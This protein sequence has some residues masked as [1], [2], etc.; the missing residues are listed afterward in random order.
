[1]CFGSSPQ[2]PEIK[3]QGP[4]DDDIA[5][6]EASLATYQQQLQ[7]QQAASA[8]QLQEQIDAANKK[9]AELQAQYDKEL[10][11]VSAEAAATTASANNAANY[12]ITATQTEAPTAQTTTTFK[13]KKKPVGSLKIEPGAI[14]SAGSGLNIGV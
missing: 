4:S 5:R 3:Y 11:S 13:P 6:Q 14:A 10:A 2:A 9:T 7:E 12:A 8:K 1:M